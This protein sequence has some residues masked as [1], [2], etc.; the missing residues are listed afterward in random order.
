MATK[1]GYH[2]QGWTPG[3]LETVLRANAPV[4]KTMAQDA[5]PIRAVL[6]ARGDVQIIVRRYFDDA[7][8][9]RL[10]QA[11]YAGGK[12][13][14]AMVAAQFRDVAKVVPKLQLWAEGLNETGLWNDAAAYNAF[15]VGFAEE[16]RRQG[17]R[18]LVYSFPTGNPPGYI[19][20]SPEDLA[21]YWAHYLDGLRAAKACDGGLAL[22]EYSAPR[23]QDQE[24]WLCLRY[25][26]VYAVLPSDLRDLPLMITE[27][28]IDGGVVGAPV[29]N[30]GWRAF[31]SVGEYVAQL[32]WYDTAIAEDEYVLGATIFTAG[33]LDKWSSFD[34]TNVIEIAEMI[35]ERNSVMVVG[36]RRTW[37]VYDQAWSALDEAQRAADRA[38]DSPLVRA[39]ETA[40]DIIRARKGELTK[41]R[42]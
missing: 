29:E 17:F 15:S 7:E 35:A 19:D 30:A 11:R 8:Q 1:L 6:R 10:L 31:A 27:C 32:A 38:Q 22:H 2:V 39:I 3:T 4:L 26:R 20:G 25:R 21:R 14:A 23:M 9:A 16:C 13:C 12:E 18:P 34:V 42:S 36:A 33:N 28:G 41:G 40:K 24:T 5:E 37:D